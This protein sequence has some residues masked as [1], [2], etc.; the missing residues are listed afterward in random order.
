[1]ACGQN[2]AHLGHVQLLVE[3]ELGSA[4]GVAQILLRH[5]VG[6]IALEGPQSARVAPQIPVQ[7]KQT[8]Q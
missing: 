5:L 6:R 2:G 3:E 4:L 7:V 1:M 8:I